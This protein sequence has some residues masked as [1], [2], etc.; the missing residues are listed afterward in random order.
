MKE[1]IVRKNASLSV[2]LFTTLERPCQKR[3]INTVAFVNVFVQC[4]PQMEHLRKCNSKKVGDVGIGN[5]HN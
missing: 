1:R 5:Q 4:S 3:D 2:H